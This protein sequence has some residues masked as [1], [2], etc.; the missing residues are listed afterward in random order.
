MIYNVV[1]ISFFSIFTFI[2]TYS[3][4]FALK[5]LCKGGVGGA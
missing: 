4:V 3:I 5:V 2:G 1:L